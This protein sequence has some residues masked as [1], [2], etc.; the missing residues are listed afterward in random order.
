MPASLRFQVKL[1]LAGNGPTN[2]SRINLVT[3]FNLVPLDKQ[4][5]HGVLL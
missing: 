4:Q 5:F 2:Y 1:S 3:L